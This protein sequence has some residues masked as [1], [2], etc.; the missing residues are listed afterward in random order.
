MGVPRSRAVFVRHRWSDQA[1]ETGSMPDAA[2]WPARFFG[3]NASYRGELEIS[4][5]STTTIRAAA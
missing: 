2:A 4:S 3:K 1:A 5:R